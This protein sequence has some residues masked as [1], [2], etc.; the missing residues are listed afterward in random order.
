VATSQAIYS[1]GA[2][3]RMLGVAA[4]VLRTWEDRYGVVV[5]ERS[6]GG[7][8]LYT[9]H[10][11][12]RLRAVCTRIEDGLSAADAH[13][14]LALDLDL[15]RGP[16][17]PT[18]TP[19]TPPSAAAT[20]VVLVERDRH[21]GELVASGLER[22]GHAVVTVR[23][24]DAAVGVVAE[25]QPDLV[26]VDLMTGGGAGLDVCRAL[27]D[28]APVVAVSVLDQRDAAADAGAVAFLRKPLDLPALVTTVGDLLAPTPAG[29]PQRATLA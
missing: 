5:P 7:Q 24:A 16:T 18:S 22:A 1:I 3:S 23:E 9:Q 4:T 10:H 28:G 20:R 27:R 26:I 19:P 14:L 12:E 21:A 2:V 25:Q 8:R 29:R 11:V 15:D 13:R 17:P 6:A